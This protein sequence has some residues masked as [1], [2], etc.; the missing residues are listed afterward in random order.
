MKWFYYCCNIMRHPSKLHRSRTR[1]G[2]NYAIGSCITSLI[3][4]RYEIIVIELA[5][6]LGEWCFHLS[7]NPSRTD[8]SN[9]RRLGYTAVRGGIEAGDQMKCPLPGLGYT[10]KNSAVRVSP[11][12]S[13]RKYLEGFLNRRLDPILWCWRCVRTSSS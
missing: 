7:M 6:L 4:G 3:T 12:F 9:T 2:L 8:Q 11:F 10:N 13:S 5:E 1:S